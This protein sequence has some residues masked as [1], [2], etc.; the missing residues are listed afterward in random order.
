MNI[1]A[2]FGEENVVEPEGGV[3]VGGVS[4]FGNVEEGGNEG[5]I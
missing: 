5:G 3:L 4:E 1:K 2:E